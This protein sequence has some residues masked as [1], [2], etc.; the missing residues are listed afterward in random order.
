MYLFDD[1]KICDIPFFRRLIYVEAV[2]SPRSIVPKTQETPG[3]VQNLW[4]ILF[5]NW[6]GFYSDFLYFWFPRIKHF[7]GDL[8]FWQKFVAFN[9]KSSH[10]FIMLRFPLSFEM[11]LKCFIPLGLSSLERYHTIIKKKKTAIKNVFSF[12][13]FC[14][15][16]QLSES[17]VKHTDRII[18]LSKIILT[19]ILISHFTDHY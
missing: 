1:P 11:A 2:S 5:R 16:W 19:I 4:K 8:Y 10:K 17:N 7:S 18:N 12:F 14:S 3:I 15:F 9:F 6:P 13:S